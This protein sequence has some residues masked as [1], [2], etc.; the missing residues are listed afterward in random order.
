MRELK[1]EKVT[2]ILHRLAAEFIRLEATP[3]SLITVTRVELNPSGKNAHVFF[4]TLPQDREEAA[5]KFLER[6]TTEFKLFA[7]D[8]SR[9]GMLP[10]VDFKIDFGERNR[11]RLDELTRDEEN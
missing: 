1:K 10:H 4:T 3:S 8:H 6:K 2:E 9:I 7:R 11:Q 5:L